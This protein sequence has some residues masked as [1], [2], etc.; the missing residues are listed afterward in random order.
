MTTSSWNVTKKPFFIGLVIS[1]FAIG[2][3]SAE[4]SSP[5]EKQRAENAFFRGSHLL[6]REN[7]TEALPALEEAMQLDPENAKFKR[8]LAIAYNNYGIRLNKE[9]KV[10]EALKSFEKALGVQP[11]DKGIQTNLIN[12]CIQAVSAPSNKLAEKE[13]I[14]FLKK[15]LELNPKEV[16]AKKALAAILNNQGVS[17]SDS[18]NSQDEI[19]RL[20]DALSFDP[21]NLAIKKNL[22]IAYYNLGIAKGKSRA[23]EE[24]IDL[25]KKSEK[26]G[27]KDRE[28]S[29]A[30]ASALSNLAVT[31]GSAGDFKSQ[32]SLL[33]EA[34][35]LSPNDMTIKKNLAGAYN[36]Y[37]VKDAS[38]GFS[39]KTSNLENALKLDPRNQLTHSNLS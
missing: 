5:T 24:E 11:D 37:A 29:Q 18:S 7:M 4:S 39:D 9:G 26:L 16:V 21:G 34:L 2:F 3:A 15:V 36:N 28:I 8:V 23:Y 19:K 6:S 25:L 17:K 20:E 35:K 14:Y 12:A 13:K 32:I 30:M 31:K 27:V 10:L 22:G 1:L 33:K 38:L